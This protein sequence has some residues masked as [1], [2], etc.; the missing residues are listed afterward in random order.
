[1]QA[2]IQFATGGRAPLKESGQTLVE[3]GLILGLI[4]IVVVVLLTTVGDAIRNVFNTIINS[5]D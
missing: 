5:F 4:S 1:M 2:V 3:Y